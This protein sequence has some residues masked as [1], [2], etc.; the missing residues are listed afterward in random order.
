MLKFWPLGVKRKPPESRFFSTFSPN[1]PVS[2]QFQLKPAKTNE[3]DGVFASII[4]AFA[5]L[6]FLFGIPGLLGV[7]D[8]D[9]PAPLRGALSPEKA[10]E[11]GLF[12]ALGAGF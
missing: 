6:D 3:K 11:S 5:V 2:I 12:P 9:K 1:P 7:P 8:R 10:L 4:L